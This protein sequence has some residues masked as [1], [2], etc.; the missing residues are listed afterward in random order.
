M[1]HSLATSNFRSFH[2]LQVGR[3][4]PRFQKKKKMMMIMSFSGVG[5]V[6]RQMATSLGQTLTI[7]HQELHFEIMV[8]FIGIYTKTLTFDIGDEFEIDVGPTVNTQVT[9]QFVLTHC[10]LQEEH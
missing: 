1:E 9:K 6:K 10:T 3:I 4:I 8:T 2:L 7:N 5:W